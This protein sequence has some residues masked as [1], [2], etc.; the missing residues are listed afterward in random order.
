MKKILLPIVALAAFLGTSCTS[1]VAVNSKT[2]PVAT[3]DSFTGTF[4]GYIDGTAPK[5]FMATQIAAEKNLGYFRTGIRDDTN[6]FK[7]RCRTATDKP[8]MV[9]VTQKDIDLV[10][11]EIDFD[12]GDQMQSQI[13]FNEIVKAKSGM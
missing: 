9:T 3:Y 10:E 7:L 4:T 5:I 13:F 1:E 8:V 6:K 11:V 2:N 12:G